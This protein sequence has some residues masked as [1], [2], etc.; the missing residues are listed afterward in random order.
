MSDARVAHDV[1]ITD[2][3]LRDGSHAMAHQF[4]EAQVR[5]TV[6]ALDAAGVEVIEVTHGD[7][8]GGS[9]S[10]TASPA[11]DEISSS[12]PPSRR[13]SRRRSR[14]CSCPASA[15]WRTCSGPT[16]RARQGA[17]I[18]THCTEAD[19]S[20]QHFG[21][22]RDAGHGDRRVPH[23]GPPHLA[24]GAR[25]AGPDHGRRGR[26]CVYFVDSAGALVL[27]G[28]G[29]G[30]GD[31]RGGRRRGPGR[32][33][34]PPEPVLRRGQLGA[35]ATRRRPPDRRLA[36]RAGRGRGQLADRGARRRRSTGSASTPAS[37]SAGCSP[38]PRTSSTRTCAVAVDGPQ[39]D[40]AGLGGR[41]LDLPAARRARRRALRRP[42]ARDPAAAAASSGY[43]GGQ[44]DMI[45]DVAIEL[46]EASGARRRSGAVRARHRRPRGIRR[47]HVRLGRPVDPRAV[48]DGRAGRRG[49]GRPGRRRGPP[50]VRRGSV[51][52]DGLRRAGRADPP[53]RRPAGGAPRVARP[54]RHP[55]HGQADQRRPRQGRAARGAELPVLR[56]PRAPGHGRDPADGHRPPRLHPLRARGRRR[57]DRAVELP[58]HAGELEGRARAGLGQHRGAQARGGHAGSG[59]DHGPARAGGGHP[60]GRVQRAA[61]LRAGRGGF[62]AHRRTAGSTG[63]RS[64][65]SA[66]TG[67]AI[68]GAAA[69][70][71]TPVSLE[72]GGK[73]AN[74]VFADAD[75]DTAVEWSIKAIFSNAGQV[76]LAGSRLYVERA[77]LDEFLARFVAAAEATA[78]RRPE[79]R[80][81][82]AG[83]ARLGDALAQGRAATSRTRGGR[84]LTGGWARVG[85]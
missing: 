10:T 50:G 54:R 58:A 11:A 39:R 16:T 34:R 62:G 55:R 25:A 27:T 63:S 9:R 17:R 23:D 74:L 6:H 52:A 66:N 47:R 67:R 26:Q 13:R 8:L 61:R 68:A 21:L 18:A 48:G 2:T 72:L 60:A 70:N 7:G 82:R 53:L 65:A 81:H 46:A 38:R 14:C 45:I 43:V 28:A 84:I 51:A 44:E 57:G 33:P 12:P 85:S 3:T 1:R 42:R 80:G 73:G 20:I 59:D 29:A 83:P 64:P 32:L 19:V 5:A 79:G 4:T 15:R 76:C 77:V 71:L 40:R 78:D 35:G 31:R 24:G 41:L 22:A 37:T 49:R 69:R 56:R 30:R 75:L 36:V